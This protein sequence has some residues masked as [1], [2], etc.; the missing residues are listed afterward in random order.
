MILRVMCR[1]YNVDGNKK[2]SAHRSGLIS[3]YN[4][5]IL[6]TQHPNFKAG[7]SLRFA[8]RLMNPSKSH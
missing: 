8:Q 2:G 3:N 1:F 4:V 5:F 7:E 6:G